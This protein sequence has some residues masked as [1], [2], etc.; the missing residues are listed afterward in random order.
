[1]KVLI[2]EDDSHIR[3]GL[4]EILQ[5]RA[6]GR[7]GLDETTLFISAGLAGTEVLLARALLDAVRSD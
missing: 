2:V 7:T 1:M 4:E 6:P 3:A 5:G